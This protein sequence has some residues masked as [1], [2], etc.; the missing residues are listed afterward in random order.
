MASGAWQVVVLVLLAVLPAIPVLQL[1]LHRRRGTAYLV[2]EGLAHEVKRRGRYSGVRICF[3]SECY[4]SEKLICT[5]GICTPEVSRL[6]ANPSIEKIRISLPGAQFE[7]EAILS[8]HMFRI[9]G[10]LYRSGKLYIL[11]PHPDNPQRIV[12]KMVYGPGRV[13]MTIGLGVKAGQAYLMGCSSY[14]IT[15]IL[16]TP[17]E[18]DVRTLDFT[19]T[20]MDKIGRYAIRIR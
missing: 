17:R 16:E 18:K 3:N 15:L 10:T 13:E 14:S 8:T 12:R 19:C 5:R 6:E 2:T 1:V 9:E 4:G 7:G 11:L 20:K